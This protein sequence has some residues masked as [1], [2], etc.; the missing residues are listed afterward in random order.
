MSNGVYNDT[1]VKVQYFNA[2]PYPAPVVSSFTP[3]TGN[4]GTVV[5]ITGSYFSN[6]QAVSFGGIPANSFTVVSLTTITATVGAGANGAVAVTTPAGTGLLTGFIT[7]PPPVISSFSPAS[8]PVGSVITIYG[9]NFST[10]PSQNI[11]YIGRIKATV[12]SAS[13]TQLSVTVP[14]A[15]SYHP[16][17]V[18]VNKHTAYS[19][20]PFVVTFPVTCNFTDYTFS[21]EVSF[22]VSREISDFTT[23]DLNNDGKTDIAAAFSNGLVVM[24]N[25]STATQSRFDTSILMTISPQ[26]QVT[27]IC[28]ADFDGDNKPDIAVTNRY[29]S[30]VSLFQN[31]STSTNISF[32]PRIDF[33]CGVSPT[34]IIADDLD[35][36]G[37][38]DIAL[39]NANTNNDTVTLLRNISLNSVINFGPRK[40]IKARLANALLSA[41]IDG[42]GKK[43]LITRGIPNNI[44]GDNITGFLV[45]KNT[46]GIGDITFAGKMNIPYS[47]GYGDTKIGD[48]DS[49][50]KP[51]IIMGGGS[52]NAVYRNTS[53]VN[54]ISFVTT[55]LNDCSAS[56]NTL[57]DLDGDGKIDV[58]STCALL[59]NISTPG[60][61]STLVVDGPYNSTAINVGIA[62]VNG[63]GRQDL[64]TASSGF[65][66]I[67][68]R[69][70]TLGVHG[71]WAG[72]DTTICLGQEVILGNAVTAGNTVTGY[73]YVWTSSPAGYASGDANPTVSPA[74]TTIYYVTVTN[75]QGCTMYDSVKITVGGAAP[76]ETNI[77]AEYYKCIGDTVYINNPA[78]G[79]NTYSWQSIPAGF[80]SS[81]PN[82]VIIPPIGGSQ[83]ILTIN[84]GYC[85]AK[86][87]VTFTVY[88][89]PIANGGSDRIICPSGITI[90]TSG[91]M[92][93][94][95]AWTSSDGLY[96]GSTSYATPIL[97]TT[98]SYYLKVT[99][100]AG[101]IARDTV[102]VT[103]LNRPAANGGPDKTICGSDSIIIGTSSDT[104]LTY[105]WTT[106]AGLYSNLA[107]P[108]VRPAATTTYYLNVSNGACATRDT[109][110]VTIFP[111]IPTLSLTASDTS[112]CPGN[113][114]LFNTSATNS[115]SGLVYQWKKNGLNTGTNSATYSTNTLQHQDTVWTVLSGDIGCTEPSVVNSNKIVIRIENEWTGTSSTAWEQPSNWSCGTVPGANT[116]VLIRSGNVIINSNAFCRT[117]RVLPGAVVS[118]APGFSLTITR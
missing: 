46:S 27:D 67:Y 98:T 72:N 2:A 114:V 16:I 42:D 109:V 86:D 14:A 44:N 39:I 118:V 8:G 3:V 28:V 49:D 75:P 23:V 116:N 59:K 34:S 22:N 61:L 5:T 32:A 90:G 47:I 73:Q 25:I 55:F 37:K 80:T 38:P 101:C 6:V 81:L 10:T 20:L 31:T 13:G 17:S 24:K 110:T 65:S 71:M 15:G 19:R 41:D 4:T 96:T 91:N 107:T 57:G 79:T 58:Y 99:N 105:S 11:V 33:A 1:T 35:N 97:N 7:V 45:F 52:N 111:G 29:T 69:Q 60:N 113:T 12:N 83:Y 87:T 84:T 95:Y 51:D 74:V 62:D 100:M 103:V 108:K 43:D 92:Y 106:S 21:N 94:T 54:S 53:T 102:L 56:A 112:I 48:M 89:L 30:S 40:F 115:N 36:D 68:V 70:N 85:V 117:I 63:D 26:A 76:A 78:S 88:T 64:L 9:N 93:D 77:P 50:G 18:T 82:P 104:V 66:K